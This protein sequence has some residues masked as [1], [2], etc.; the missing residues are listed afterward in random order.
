MTIVS[1]VGLSMQIGLRSIG[2]WPNAPYAFLFRGAWILT[3]GIVQTFQYWW[4]V[5]HF[6][7]DDM[8]H[9]IDGLSVTVEYTLMSLKLIIL[10]LNSRIFY[11]VLAAMAADWK[12][13]A[14]NE[15][16][17]MTSKANISRYIANVIIGLH[18]AAV[19]VYVIDVLVFRTSNYNVDGI[20]TSV[21]EFTLKLQLPF[22]CNE[23]PLYEVIMLLEFLHQL[24]AS[25]TNGVLNC[26]IITLILHISGQIE[27]LCNALRDISLGKNNQEELILSIKALISKHQKI[28]VFSGSIEQIFCYIALIQVL[29]S[30]LVICCLGFMIVTSINTQ[31]SN[32][33]D[34]SGLIKSLIFY[35]V[36]T[37]EAFI[38]CFCGEYL[39]AKS[40]M[41]GDAAYNSIWYDFKL[42]ECKLVLFIILRSQRR[43]TITAGKMMDLSLEGFTSIMKASLSYVSILHAMY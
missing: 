22:E 8:S 31:D 42:N 35:M 10:W 18:S 36:V 6:G 26:L 41:I 9:L 25:A 11:D 3:T 39:S 38:F 20:E 37:I 2:I 12:E 5:I 1:T 40:K 28:I 15:M 33:I 14:I 16:Q 30:T 27:I 13:A 21:R 29:S 32:T 23:S 24:V 7:N 17:T 4:V 34:S 43:L 19:I